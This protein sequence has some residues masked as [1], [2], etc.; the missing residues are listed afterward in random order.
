MTTTVRG[1]HQSGTWA[2]FPDPSATTSCHSC[3]AYFSPV[4]WPSFC[5]CTGGG[6]STQCS[7]SYSGATR[8]DRVTACV[9]R[10]RVA[11][12]SPIGLVAT[13]RS[14]LVCTLWRAVGRHQRGSVTRRAERGPAMN[15]ASARAGWHIVVS[16]AVPVAVAPTAPAAARSSACVNRTALERRLIDRTTISPPH[17]L[18][19]THARNTLNRCCTCA[20]A[21]WCHRDP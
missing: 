6:C 16:V 8:Q 4:G 17:N 7:V 14:V 10:A 15:V 21:P 19:L 9:P 12:A 20:P 5:A 1:H 11:Y 2:L 18:L 13:R 3:H